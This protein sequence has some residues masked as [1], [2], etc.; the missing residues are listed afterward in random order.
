MYMLPKFH[1]ELNPI[2]HVWA[3]SKRYTKAY[4]K[5]SIIS[6]LKLHVV[7]PILEAVTLVNIQSFFFLVQTSLKIL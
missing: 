3:H 2:E 6:L 4:C 5:Y 7:V 1:C